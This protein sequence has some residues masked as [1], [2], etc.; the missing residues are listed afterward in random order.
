MDSAANVMEYLEMG[1]TTLLIDEDTS[2]TNF[3][4]RDERMQM[5]VSDECEPI[6]PFSYRVRFSSDVVCHFIVFYSRSRGNR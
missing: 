6:T 5:L 3:M 4:M 1:C 2:A